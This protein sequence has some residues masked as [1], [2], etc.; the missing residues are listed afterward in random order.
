MAETIGPLLLWSLRLQDFDSKE[1]KEIEV[2]VQEAIATL[3]TIF[4]LGMEKA[5]SGLR[6]S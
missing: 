1:Q 2:A 6:V 3:A 4:K 5:L